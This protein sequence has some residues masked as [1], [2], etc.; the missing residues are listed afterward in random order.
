M[1]VMRGEGRWRGRQGTDFE[2]LVYCAKKLGF[3][4]GTSWSHWKIL[5]QE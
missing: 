3:I 1:Q 5:M 2:W 4:M